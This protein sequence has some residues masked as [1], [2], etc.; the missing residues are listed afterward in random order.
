VLA[1]PPFHSTQGQNESGQATYLRVNP[2]LRLV[3]DSHHIA[4]RLALA[5]LWRHASHCV[6]PVNLLDRARR[7]VGFRLEAQP[8]DIGSGL[9]S[10]TVLCLL[11]L[12]VTEADDVEVGRAVID[13]KVRANG[14]GRLFNG[15]KSGCRRVGVVCQGARGVEELRDRADGG[16]GRGEVGGAGIVLR[17]FAQCDENELETR[18]WWSEGAGGLREAGEVTC[19]RRRFGEGGVSCGFVGAALVVKMTEVCMM[20]VGR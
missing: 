3:L 1:Y 4:C 9:G 2:V 11:R 14:F 10:I 19:W 7:A 6:Q 15:A 18:A 16:R 13:E 17:A 8:L 12:R 20:R 5:C